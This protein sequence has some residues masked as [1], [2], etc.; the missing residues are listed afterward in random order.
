MLKCKLMLCLSFSYWRC[1]CVDIAS[2]RT[3]D[4]QIRKR[5]KRA[6]EGQVTERMFFQGMG[7]VV[8][9][10]KGLISVP[11]SQNQPTKIVRPWCFDECDWISP[12]VFT[13]VP[14]LL[15]FAYTLAES[16]KELQFFLLWFANR[17]GQP[18]DS[19]PCLG[20]DED[21][22]QPNCGHAPESGGSYF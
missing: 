8:A 10:L 19:Y 18:S 15:D 4:L 21:P 5:N 12:L 16:F 1:C 14:A 6:R 11:Q 7:R 13:M 22:P 20:N 9:T 3:I 2:A 17:P